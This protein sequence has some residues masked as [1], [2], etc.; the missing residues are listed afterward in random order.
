M[1][2]RIAIATGLC[3]AAAP[4]AA[5]AFLPATPAQAIERTEPKQEIA[6]DAAVMGF[7]QEGATINVSLMASD[8]GQ[9][10]YVED[11]ANNI[12]EIPVSPG[13][14]S[15]SAQLPANFVT[16]DALIIRVH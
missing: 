4:I 15:V 7:S 8:D 2:T 10:V 11:A 6:L 12:L 16:S 5:M 14:T 1:S 13:Q 3:L 9:H